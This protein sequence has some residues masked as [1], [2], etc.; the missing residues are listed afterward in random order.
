MIISVNSNIRNYN[1]VIE[2][3]ALNCVSKY[4]NLERK[5][6][7]V[8]DSGVP[9]IYA[10]TVAKQCT[11]PYIITIKQGELSKS[12]ETFKDLLLKM[13]ENSFT[14]TDAVVAVGGGV[15]GD[16]AGFV[17]ASFNRGVDFCNIPTTVLSQVDSSIGGKVAVDFEGY[18]NIIGAFYPPKTVIIDRDTLKT[19]DKRQISNGLAESL[20]MALTS[21]EELFNI[22]Y[23]NDIDQ[24]IDKILELSLVIKKDV[25]EK[26]E[27]EGGL[28]KILNFGHTVAHAIECEDTNKELL[29]GECVGLGMLPMCSESV[30][31]KLLFVLKKLNLPTKIP[32]NLEKLKEAI[33]H[34]KKMAGKKITV[35]FVEKIG[36]FEMK[37]IALDEYFEFLKEGGLIWKIRLVAA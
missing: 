3:G 25:V 34:D 15:V 8:T 21:S 9:E 31:N 1:V 19:L 35:V 33:S 10:K 12:F 2:R 29:H 14:R 27:K 18:K 37:T 6:L 17:A 36:Q 28:R 24:N 30:R 4:F 22:F 23:E 16:L 26:D 5:V 20:K 11:N 13:V 32:Y 7:I